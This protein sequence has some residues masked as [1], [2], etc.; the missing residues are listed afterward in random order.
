M[1]EQPVALITGASRGIGRAIALR[2]AGDHDIL[3]AARSRPELESL[4][5]EIEAAGGKC[6]TIVMDV[7]DGA[8]VARALEGVQADVLVNNAGVGYLKPFMELTPDEWNAMVGVNLN[9]LFH[10]TRAV[11]PG[12]TA[13]EHGHIVVIGSITGRTAFRGG[14]GYAA[15]KHAAMGFTECLMLEARDHGV[16]V[17]VVNPGS[18]ITEFGSGEAL[19]KDWAL[20]PEDV[21]DA[22]AAVLAT[23]AKVLIHRVEIRGAFPK[24]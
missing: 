1:R 19:S 5:G 17:S 24:K 14:T 3:A 4:R 20:R 8:A 12:M 13:R 18:V 2:L 11:L 15:T 9:A 7:S 16:K 6:T 21:S 22:V 10:V 23:P